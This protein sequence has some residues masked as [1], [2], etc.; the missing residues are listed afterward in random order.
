MLWYYSSKNSIYRNNITNNAQ[1][2]IF[3][4]HSS[5]NS[6]Y[7]NNIMNNGCGIDLFRSSGN[8]I[9]H[10]NFINNVRQVCSYESV[11]VWDDGYP[12]G[13]NYWSDYVGVDEKSGPRQDKPGSDGIGDTSYVIDYHNVDRYP[14]MRP[15]KPPLGDINGDGVVDIYDIV[16]ATVAYGSKLGDPHWNPRAD[17]APPWGVINIYDIVTIASNYVR[18]R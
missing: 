16:L 17:I 18:K 11:N 13:G 2:G 5:N 7:G 8:R 1:Y 3:L 4:E 10:N 15:W 6:I 12:S 9:F 14:L